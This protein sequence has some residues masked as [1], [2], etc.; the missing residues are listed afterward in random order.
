MEQEHIN[1]SY[2]DMPKGQSQ[3]LDQMMKRKF[4][5]QESI[6]CEVNKEY[7]TAQTQS[8][9]NGIQKELNRS[10]PNSQEE[11]KMYISNT[12]Q[13]NGNQQLGEFNQVNASGESLGSS[14]QNPQGGLN[15]VNTAQ[16]RNTGLDQ[17]DN[18]QN[19]VKLD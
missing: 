8:L 19:Q 18:N 9:A 12:D 13:T 3:D 10:K 14:L 4:K 17:S 16:Q 6:I 5:M 11:S 7:E 1:L 2:G 15:A